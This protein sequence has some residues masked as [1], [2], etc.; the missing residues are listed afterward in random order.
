MKW[1]GT[2][3][4]HEALFGQNQTLSEML[5][6]EKEEWE[7]RRSLIGTEIQTANFEGK[8]TSSSSQN[9][10]CIDSMFHK[11]SKSIQANNSAN[12]PRAETRVRAASKPEYDCIISNAS[13]SSIESDCIIEE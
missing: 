8:S 6:I 2:L 13:S 5:L 11:S 9:I 10:G 12:F 3:L 4:E 1:E 7:L